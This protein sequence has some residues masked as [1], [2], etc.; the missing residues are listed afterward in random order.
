MSLAFKILD[1]TLSQNE[2]KGLPGGSKLL[3][4]G[5]LSS[6]YLPEY[7]PKRVDIC[8][9]A[10]FTTVDELWG[11]P[12]EGTL[13]AGHHGGLVHQDLGQTH[14]LHVQDLPSDLSCHLLPLIS[15]RHPFRGVLEAGHHG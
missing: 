4:V 1:V 5:P 7:D 2:S 12:L 3:P 8:L 13:E 14:I 15:S 9:L 11:C 10:A 6:D